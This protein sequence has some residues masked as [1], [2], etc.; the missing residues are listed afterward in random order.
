MELGEFARAIIDLVN[1]EKSTDHDTLVGAMTELIK[2]QTGIALDKDMGSKATT[3]AKWLV[4]EMM[5]DDGFLEGE[6]PMM[7]MVQAMPIQDRKTLLMAVS[8]ETDRRYITQADYRASVK[9]RQLE[10]EMAIELS[11]LENMT[12]Q[13]RKELDKH[14]ELAYETRL[15][16]MM[17]VDAR[18]TELF[19][20]EDMQHPGPEVEHKPVDQQL[21]GNF[22]EELGIETEEVDYDDIELI[23]EI[24]QMAYHRQELWK[25]VYGVS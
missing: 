9:R 13:E 10:N 25:G 15:E 2:I 20:Q 21:I 24:E 5:G 1:E 11:V 19:L 17:E 7:A 8:L 12:E 23:N 18:T 22:L 6:D 4:S 16:A 3:A 14:K